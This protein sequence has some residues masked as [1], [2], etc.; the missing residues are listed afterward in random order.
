MMAPQ[1]VLQLLTE[2]LAAS[3]LMLADARADAWPQLIEHDASRQ[4]LIVQLMQIEWPTADWS[5]EERERA[6][7]LVRQIA[8]DNAEITRMSTAWH[9]ELKSILAQARISS[10]V[11][12]MYAGNSG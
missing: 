4:L 9:A 5:T 12:D 3:R 6:A 11:S 1:Q 8:D 7:E 2:I 10:R